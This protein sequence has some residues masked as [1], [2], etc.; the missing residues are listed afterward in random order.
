MQNPFSWK[1]SVLLTFGTAAVLALGILDARAAA[2]TQQAESV[3]VLNMPLGDHSTASESAVTITD[4]GARLSPTPAAELR[5]LKRLSGGTEATAIAIEEQAADGREAT[6]ELVVRECEMNGPTGSAPSDVH[7]AAALTNII[8]VTNVDIMI[9]R[10][11]DCLLVSSMSLKSFFGGAGGF[12]I[13]AAE[14]LFDPRVVYDRL[15]NRCI[16]TVESR[17]SGNTDQFLYIASSRNSSCTTWRRVRFVLSR[18]SPA[19]LFC[20]NLASDFYDYP[21]AGYNRLR[22]AVT[23][24][25]FPA[26]GGSYG[27]LL[28]IDKIALH[29]TATVT[30]R[31][32]RPI[33]G[34]STPA[35]Q[36]DLAPHMFILS[37]G[38]GSGTVLTRRRLT[39]GAT[40]A[41]DTLTLLSSIDIPNWTAPP[42][43]VQPNG[44]R[45]DSLDGRFQSASKQIGTSIWNTHAINVGGVSRVRVYKMSTSGTMPLL[46]RDLFTTSCGSTNQHTF[47]PSLDTNSA[48]LGSPLFVTASRTCT[49]PAAVAVGRAAHLIFKG[50]NHAVAGWVFNHI[51]TSVNQFTVDGS[52]VAC[53]NTSRGSCRWGDYSS[54]QIDPSVPTT[55]WGFNQLIQTGTLGG[56]QSHFNWRTRAG[57]VN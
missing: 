14:S 37:T 38:S 7:G 54:T 36:G 43:A 22:L 3:P 15:H 34:N 32:F 5:R 10:K 33:S 16:V 27:T 26:A 29:G 18:V 24:N 46:V 30:G 41:S 56:S 4:P 35:V 13:P 23:S 51:E 31:C 6:P 39:P 28:S 2:Q 52:A 12:V 21:N 49:S 50:P 53:N 25:N 19:A 42:D 9:R 40:T 20:K 44:Q 48:V 1:T 47:N 45:L 55:A 8:E 57:L 17:N 11:T